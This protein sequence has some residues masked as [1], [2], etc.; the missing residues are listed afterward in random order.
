MLLL[1]HGDKMIDN[2]S[3]ESLI[4]QQI[5]TVV[6]Q[7]VQSMLEQTDWF[8]NI[9][10][11]VVKYT[12]DRIVS[13]F[14]NI[15]TVPD[16]ISTVESSV[17]KLFEQG[18][19]PDL[20]NFV[21]TDKINST[22]DVSVQKFIDKAIDNLVIDTNW[23]N[24]IEILVNQNMSD[25][26]DRH[27]RE[28]DLNS[29][30]VST[31]DLGIERW[32]D[33]LLKNFS[34]N[35]IRDISTTQQLTVM[36]GVVVVESDL[37]TNQLQVQKDAV[38]NGSLVTKDLV[39]SGRINVDNSSWNEL[40]EHISKHAMAQITTQWQQQL[41]DDVVNLVKQ[42]GINFDSVL[43]NGDPLLKDGVLGSSVKHA[44]FKTIGAL[45]SL[46][47]LGTTILNNT[48]H[49][50]NRRVGINTDSPEMALSVWDEEVTIIA[51]KLSKQQ[52][53][54]GTA[55]LQNLAIGINRTAHIEIDVDGLTTIKKLRIG[56][57]QLGH[58]AEVP[59]YSGTRGDIVFNS[60]PTPGSPFAWRCLGSFQWQP[61]LS[62]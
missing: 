10:Q 6:E 32:Q 35:G 45:D 49:V 27:L 5:K 9:E 54:L 30:L 38:I 41:V 31:I 7:R 18:R 42:D 50:H 46:Q 29:L 12:Q 59:G 55:R 23:I 25:K 28:I 11:R 15:S 13:R 16:L 57:H 33:R 60:N 58:A 17:E 37:V 56:R 43:I 61:L 39:V 40:S 47:V 34:T 44:N 24:K 14:A 36:D 1:I 2:T 20:A 62:V 51:G 3:L 21:N 4:E 48:V 19:I 8:N 52:G 26:L 22:I 53:Y